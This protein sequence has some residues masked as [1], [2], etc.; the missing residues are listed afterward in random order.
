MM[1]SV[2]DIIHML[3]RDESENRSACIWTYVILE[4]GN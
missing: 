2:Y 1:F 4:C 3:F